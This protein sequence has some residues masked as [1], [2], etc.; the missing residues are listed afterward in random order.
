MGAGER[1]AHTSRQA[2]EAGERLRPGKY[3]HDDDDE[4]DDEEGE[5]R[6]VLLRG[7]SA[8]RRR[9][10]GTGNNLVPER[11]ETGRR[12]QSIL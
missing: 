3:D 10:R 5:R 6:A 12:G 1:D 9:D 4:N 8:R 2:Q 7:S 11:W